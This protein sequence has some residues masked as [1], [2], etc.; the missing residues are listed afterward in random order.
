[1]SSA[2]VFRPSEEPLVLRGAITTGATQSMDTFK[3]DAGPLALGRPST[4]SGYRFGHLSHNAFFARH[5][6]HP[7]R[8]RHMK[9]EI[10]IN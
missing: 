5:N 1:M 9:G 7:T 10:L 2:E 3:K 4:Q 8:V 6:P